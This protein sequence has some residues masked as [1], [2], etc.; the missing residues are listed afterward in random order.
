MYSSSRNIFFYYH[1]KDNYFH[2]VNFELLSVMPIVNGVIFLL[3]FIKHTNTTGT[4]EHTMNTPF[5]THSIHP[6]HLLNVLLPSLWLNLVW[7][8]KTKQRLC[9]ARELD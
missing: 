1:I 6:G 3:I 2:E 9:N 4:E 5:P 8:N 7:K